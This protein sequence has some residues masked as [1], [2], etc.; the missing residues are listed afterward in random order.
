MIRQFD[1]VAN[2]LRSNR[3]E[4]PYLLSVQHHLLDELATR[5]VAP[6]CREPPKLPI[7][8]CPPLSVDG[9]TVFLDPTDIYA[10]AIRRLSDPIF[11]LAADRER[12]IAALDL[13]F[14]GV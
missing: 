11:N 14:T 3:S 9:T 12:I 6:L 4:I 1:V 8:F 5:L 13:V 2:P 10:A 7:R